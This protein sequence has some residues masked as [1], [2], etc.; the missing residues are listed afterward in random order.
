MAE[1]SK[2]SCEGRERGAILLIVLWTVALMSLVVTT[3]AAHV[4]TGLDAAAVEVDRARSDL[5]LEASLDVAAALLLAKLPKE[6]GFADGR[7]SRA[8]VDGATLD[9][10]IQDASGLVDINRADPT[11]LGGLIA[12]VSGSADAAEALA[13]R[14]AEK[15]AP[16]PAADGQPSKKAPLAPFTSLAQLY[17]LEGAEPAVVAALLPYLSLYSR[18]GKLALATAPEAVLASVPGMTA[19]DVKTLVSARAAKTLDRPEAKAVIERVGQFLSTEE[20]TVF[21]VDAK[22]VQGERLIAGTRLTATILLDKEG[23]R[24]FH[25]MNLSW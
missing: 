6:P 5:I 21:I 1:R 8:R 22:I 20:S 16:P 13:W 7:R 12:R 25:V 11:L 10:A 18:D 19:E 4:R 3:L 2:G 9:I 23:D 14:I 24:P 15:R 17:G